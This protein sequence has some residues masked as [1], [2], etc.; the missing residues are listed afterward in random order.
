[1][2]SVLIVFVLLLG[3]S[4]PAQAVEYSELWGQNGELWNPNGRLPD[5]SQAGY[6]QGNTALPTI[7]PTRTVK[8]Y[9]AKGDGVTDDTRAL[10]EAV[11]AGGHLLIPAGRYI[12][13]TPIEFSK[14]GTV[15]KGEGIG[16]TVIYIPVSLEQVL[17]RSY[18]AGNLSN[19]SFDGGFLRRHTRDVIGQEIGI[20]EL[21]IEFPLTPYAGHHKEPGYNG[22]YLTHIRNCW[23][24]NVEIKNFDLGVNLGHN[25]NNCTITGVRLTGRGGHHGFRVAS[26]DNTVGSNYNLFTNFSIQNISIHDITV[27]QND[28]HNV[29]SNGTAVNMAFD[30]HGYNPHDN[31]FSNINIGAGTRPWASGGDQTAVGNGHSG[32]RE[33][34]WNVRKGDGTAL[35]QIPGFGW[36]VM[37]DGNRIHDGPTKGPIANQVNVI[38]FAFDQFGGSQ[39]IWVEGIPPALLSPVDLHAAQLAYRLGGPPPPPPPPPDTGTEPPPLPPVVNAPRNFRLVSMTP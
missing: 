13:R 32:P 22:I 39:N 38:G 28:H 33:T 7:T 21:S 24:R 2:I 26:W 30:H 11:A 14:S 31:L 12:L 6:R 23:V 36:G 37:R 9:G 18:N 34:F 25:V 8:Q 29:F 4:L 3:Y 1:M 5:F 16:R 20:E 19:Y 15:L 10:Q 17:G 35:S 27:Q